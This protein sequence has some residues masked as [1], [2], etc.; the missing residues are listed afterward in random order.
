MEHAINFTSE[1][2]K[3]GSGID[4]QTSVVYITFALMGTCGNGLVLFVVASV[5]DLRDITNIL[6]ANQSLIDFTSSILLVV[7]FVVPLPPLPANVILARV[8]CGFWYTQYPYWVTYAASMANLTIMTFERY[9][10]VVHPIQYRRRSSSRITNILVLI[11]WIFGCLQ[12]GYLIP[13]TEVDEGTCYRFLWLTKMMQPA[14][15]IYTFFI[16]LAV[17]FSLMTVLYCAIIKTLRKGLA[18]QDDKMS[19][20]HHKADYRN[21]ARRNIIRTMITLS[22]CYF[23]CYGPNITIYMIYCLGA[24][25]DLNGVEFYVTVCIAFINIWIN[26]FVYALQYRKFQRGLKQVFGC[27]KPKN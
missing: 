21:R 11:P 10:A 15:G 22:V 12:M 16:L 23:L 1:H 19:A 14:I 9:L 27:S 8:L 2:E 26:P 6:I 17:P 20:V 3:A 4:L 25:I 5:R 13:I 18:P 24:N 7:I